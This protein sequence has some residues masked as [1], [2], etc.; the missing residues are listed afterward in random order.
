MD[1]A[2]SLYVH[3]MPAGAHSDLWA[4]DFLILELQVL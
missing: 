4:L 3:H 2:E 1:D